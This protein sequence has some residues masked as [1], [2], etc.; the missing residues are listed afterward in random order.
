[1]FW[2]YWPLWH[3]REG[4]TRTRMSTVSFRAAIACRSYAEG[5]LSRSARTSRTA[6]KWS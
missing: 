5:V 4:D 6:F 3:A 2:T 1:M